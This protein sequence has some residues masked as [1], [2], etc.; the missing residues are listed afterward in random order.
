[1]VNRHLLNDLIELNLWNEDMRNE[2]IYYKGSVQVQRN[3]FVYN[4]YVYITEIIK[5]SFVSIEN[6]EYSISYKRF[7]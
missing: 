5:T 1:M 6:N 7:V 4:Y 3:C 2:L